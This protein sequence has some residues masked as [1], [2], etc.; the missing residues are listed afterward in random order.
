MMEI[1][2]HLLPIFLVVFMISLSDSAHGQAFVRTVK[3]PA[4]TQITSIYDALV[5]LGGGPNSRLRA[6]A[7][8]RRSILLAQEVM[9][10]SLAV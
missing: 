1:K 9:P 3:A 10:T 7:F 2:T 4:D 6:A 8:T 5:L